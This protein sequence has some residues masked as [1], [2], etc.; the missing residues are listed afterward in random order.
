MGIDNNDKEHVHG[1]NCD[2]GHDHGHDCNC[3]HDHS[4]SHDCDCGHD[5]GEEQ[6]TVTLTMEDDSEVE[7]VILGTFDVDEKEYIA[8][9]PMD[10][11]EVFIYNFVTLED[12]EIKLSLIEDD[13]EFQTVSD[14]FYEVFADEF[15]EFDDDEEMIEE[16]MIEEED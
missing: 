7:C 15:E 14:A 11:D 2:C 6:R 5:H 9:M 8:L 12:G 10:S 3:G 1:E 4:N 13:D 16:E